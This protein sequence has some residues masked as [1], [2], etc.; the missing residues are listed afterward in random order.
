MNISLEVYTFF[1][2]IFIGIIISIVFDVFRTIR[3]RKIYSDRAVAMQDILFWIITAIIISVAIIL[4]LK[5]KLRIYI[6]IAMFLGSIFYMLYCSKYI[7]V[8]FNFIFKYIEKVLHFI[9]VP[10][11]FLYKIVE[12][13][14]KSGCIRIKN[15]IFYIH[16]IV[17]KVKIKKGFIYEKG[18]GKKEKL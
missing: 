18:K 7:I 1:I 12:K 5:E 10:I 2:F 16:K 3:M 6:F 17:T 4:F 14:I 15:M 8:L 13:T 11:K 9:F